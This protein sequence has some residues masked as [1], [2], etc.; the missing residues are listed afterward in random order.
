M[1]TDNLNLSY[2][3]EL[4]VD[5]HYYPVG[6]D[7]NEDFWLQVS[8]DGDS[9]FSTIETWVRDTDFN[10]NT[11]YN[12]SVTITGTFTSTTQIRF[13]VD[14]SVNNDRVYFDD[15][16]ISGCSNNAR[17]GELTQ[18]EDVIDTDVTEEVDVAEVARG[19]ETTANISDMN[20]FPNPANQYINIEYTGIES[21]E[22]QLF[23]MDINGRVIQNQILNDALGQ[24]RIQLDI[25]DL[26]SGSYFIQIVAEDTVLS[27]K[28]V[29]SQTTM[30]F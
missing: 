26:T 24:Q 23:L 16:V 14:A 18:V 5:F 1:T 28:F 13:R 21:T 20:I 25:N 27:K 4:T 17:S 7:A 15:V 10:N 11:G 8:T 30:L 9:S 19:E 22:V 29:K 12:E 6:M 3:E 2:F